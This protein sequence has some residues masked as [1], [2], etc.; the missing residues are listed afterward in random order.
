MSASQIHNIDLTQVRFCLQTHPHADHLD[1]SHL[2]SRSPEYG[3]LNA[4]LLNFYA[5]SE[6]FNPLQTHSDKTLRILICYPPMG[7]TNLI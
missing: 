5:S 2:L 6:I 7:K 4:P 3:V 1:L